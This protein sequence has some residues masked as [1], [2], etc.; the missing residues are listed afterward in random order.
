MA[1]KRGAGKDQQTVV[2]MNRKA[3]FEYE[4]LDTF[5]AGIVLVGTEVKTLRTGKASIEEAYARVKDSEVFLVGAHIDEYVHGNR[6]N[7]EPRRLRKLL[8]HKR[9]IRRIRQALEQKGLT[10]IPL[11][12]FFSPRGHAKLQLGVCRGKKVRD[13]R[14]SLKKKSA[15]REM[16]EQT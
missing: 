1:D 7:H 12:L 14:E 16:R 15:Q 8:L 11:Q 6:Q 2:A 9:E 5:E 4:I 3:R 10:L 13:K